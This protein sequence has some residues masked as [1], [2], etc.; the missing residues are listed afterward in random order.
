M[1]TIVYHIGYVLVKVGGVISLVVFNY[2]DGLPNCW[3]E[4]GSNNEQVVTNCFITD[5]TN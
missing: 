5:P 3:F 2:C 1:V 4:N